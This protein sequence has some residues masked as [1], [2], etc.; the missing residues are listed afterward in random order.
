[1]EVSNKKRVNMYSPSY[2]GSRH[3]Y[4]GIGVGA[5]GIGPSDHKVEKKIKIHDYSKGHFSKAQ[6]QRN[7][8]QSGLIQR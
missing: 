4:T 6:V 3:I 2:R 1:M 5:T 7:A 8:R